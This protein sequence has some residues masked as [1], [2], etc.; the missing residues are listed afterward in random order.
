M[1]PHCRRLVKRHQERVERE[2]QV[3]REQA[4]Q[5]Q[6]LESEFAAIPTEK[7]AEA[8]S[9]WVLYE[10]ACRMSNPRKKLETLKSAR[11]LLPQEFRSARLY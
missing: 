8:G 9:A 10:Q 5:I 4:R 1:C 11:K 7:R 3:A 6:W 2:K